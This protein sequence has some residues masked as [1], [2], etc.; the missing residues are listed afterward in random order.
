METPITE[1][2]IFIRMIAMKRKFQRSG[3]FAGDFENHLFAFSLFRLEKH[4]NDL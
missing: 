1:G 4:E 2:Q 3:I